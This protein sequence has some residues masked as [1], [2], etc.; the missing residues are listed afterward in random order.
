MAV[1]K[2]GCSLLLTALALS[3]LGSPRARSQSL[4]D[5]YLESQNSQARRLKDCEE[6]KQRFNLALPGLGWGYDFRAGDRAISGTGPAAYR[7]DGDQTVFALT[8]FSCPPAD[9]YPLGKIGEIQCYRDGYEQQL[10]M[11]AGQLCLYRKSPGD[12]F[13]RSCF[14]KQAINF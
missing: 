3:V 12:F 7:I 9:E 11:E 10:L 8:E 6:F 1:V 13:S 14:V 2:A 5:Q 4:R